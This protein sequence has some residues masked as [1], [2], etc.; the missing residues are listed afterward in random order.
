[1]IKGLF[2]IILGLLITVVV[3][4]GGTALVLYISVKDDAEE[5]PYELYSE[6]ISL[7]N[8][9]SKMISGSI[10]NIKDTEEFR[11]AISE[12]LL[13]RLLFGVMKNSN[14]EYMPGDACEEA[15]C[16]YVVVERL[17]DYASFFGDR[18]V[19]VLGA[20]SEITNDEL[21]VVVVL[22]LAGIASTVRLKTSFTLENGI[23][24]LEIT[25]L[26]L[27]KINLATGIGRTILSTVLSQTDFSESTINT[28]FSESNLP[29]TFTMN[30]FTFAFA[31]SD[32][33]EVISSLFGAQEAS[34]E[35]DL[36]QELLGVLTDPAHELL[37]IGFFSEAEENYFG[38]T[39]D[40]A[41]LTY[42]ETTDGAFPIALDFEDLASDIKTL[43]DQGAITEE[44]IPLINRYLLYGYQSLEVEDQTKLN[45]LDLS[46]ISILNKGTYVPLISSDVMDMTEVF[47]EQLN[48]ALMNIS[49][50]EIEIALTAMDINSLLYSFELVGMGKAF[51]YTE[52][53]ESKLLYTGVEGAWISI[54]EDSI[55]FHFVYYLNGLRLSLFTSFED[56]STDPLT[57]E[58]SLDALRLGSLD[59]PAAMEEAVL[60]FFESFL[61]QE[62]G[63]FD[64]LAFDTENQS[65]VIDAE[66]F[67]VGLDQGGDPF[68]NDFMQ[69]LQDNQMLNLRLQATPS[70]GSFAIL[71][72]LSKFTIDPQRAVVSNEVS[73][74]VDV[75]H[76]TQIKSQSLLY[77]NLS[78]SP[79][80]YY[81]NADF[82][83]ML[84]E[85]TNGY[86]DFNYSFAL[87]NSTD[88]FSYSLN[89]I[90]L[91]F[92]TTEVSFEFLLNLNGLDT[93]IELNGTVQDNNTTE[94]KI[95]LNSTLT[96]GKDAGE[97]MAEY[98]TAE[99][100]FLLDIIETQLVDMNLIEYD[101]ILK[102]FILS[103]DTLAYFL[104]VN[105]DNSSPIL[106]TDRI[107][108]SD[109]G[110]SI[111]TSYTDGALDILMTS[112]NASVLN[113]IQ[114]N[115][116]VIADFN[117][118][119]AVEATRVTAFLAAV[120]EIA[121]ASTITASQ[122]HQ[123]IVLLHQLT[124]SNQTVFLD[125]IE[126][127]AGVLMDSLYDLIF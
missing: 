30:D 7:E 29:I 113:T 122:T 109:G 106:S 86:N 70:F 119:D 118:T 11:L 74:P 26:A 99:N 112:L 27:G 69:I 17:G 6:D 79:H 100:D 40:L 82:N 3:L 84:Y 127:D 44:D 111:Y 91:D 92:S 18:K 117:T 81:T 34:Y 9:M 123:M 89:G 32:L 105:Q 61:T 95:L 103:H 114:N 16:Q 2:K 124:K 5:I 85:N 39:L 121:N 67:L 97:T 41:S 78:D 38:F 75:P 98:A 73:D 25:K 63:G 62:E 96:L 21:E 88:V 60:G 42:D 65:L 126:A 35:M 23:Y 36:F 15:S 120:D 51:Y 48:D 50:G 24:K 33:K 37:T 110:V 10:E 22:D 28:Y 57:I 104:N 13:N 83:Q 71:G 46:S 49:S 66:S 90:F 54:K 59:L 52:G 101:P 4:V 68:L 102:A 116:P 12:T 8:E 56:T 14:P 125:A 55:R 43:L 47:T 76:F 107:E 77:G 87:P 20:Y 45:T 93:M 115:A 1:M 94:V 31:Q 58:A 19:A 72:D 108:I 64:L 53:T 80:M